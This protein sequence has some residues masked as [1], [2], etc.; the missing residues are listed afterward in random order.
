M[1]TRTRSYREQVNTIAAKMHV[2]M[3]KETLQTK[4]GVEDLIEKN[5]ALGGERIEV[6]RV[7]SALQALVDGRCG[8]FPAR[9]RDVPRSV[10][11]RAPARHDTAAG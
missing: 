3:A 5:V 6:E 2:L 1:R 10:L 8:T 4:G 9:H 11:E 7:R